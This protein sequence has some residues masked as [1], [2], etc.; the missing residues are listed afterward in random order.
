MTAGYSLAGYDAMFAD[1]VRRGAHL[2]AVRRVVRAGDVVVEV[3]TGVGYFAVAAVRAGARHVYAIE[4]APA[5]ALGEAIAS[6]NGCADRITFIHDDAA[7]A[8]LPERGTVLLCDLRGA[9]PFFV[10]GIRTLIAVRERHLLPRARLIPLRDDVFAAPCEAPQEWRATQLHLGDATD[11]IGRRAAAAVAR[12]DLTRDRITRRDLLARGARLMRLDYRTIASP[13]VS[14]EAEWTAARDGALEGFALWFTAHLAPGVRYTTAP[15]ARRTVHAQGFL[16]LERA[17]EVGAGDLIGLRFRA[18]FVDGSYV[19]AW[20]TTHRPAQG[21]PTTELRQSSLGSLLITPRDLERR[22]ATHVPAPEAVERIRELVGLIDGR[23][24]LESIAAELYR[25][26]PDW[27][28]SAADAF[29]WTVS[30]VTDTV[31]RHQP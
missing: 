25:A 30:T 20:D 6:E 24:S 21:L 17:V 12:S 14:A 1:D 22:K 5:V 31:D 28:A 26:R 29:R 16:P 19:L 7:T 11:G 2:E 18:K 9:T 8:T 13:D 15:A 4:R 3:G 23:R 10:D 27:F